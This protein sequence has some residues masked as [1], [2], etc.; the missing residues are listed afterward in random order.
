MTDWKQQQMIKASGWPLDPAGLAAGTDFNAAQE[1]G[2]VPL[3]W[4]CEHG[5]AGLLRH[6]LGHGA[7]PQTHP[8]GA[9]A[10]LTLVVRSG[11]YQAVMLLIDHL[12][13]SGEHPPGEALR[14]H[15]TD[16]F[17]VSHTNARNRLQQT[18][19][20]WDR[21]CKGAPDTRVG[22]GTQRGT[23]SATPPPGQD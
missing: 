15:L 19:R 12:K 21:L 20:D 14:K 23:K 9:Q 17:R 16:T 8:L 6:L 11:D 10:L 22:A 1:G 18:L 3:T 2:L 13:A 7:S 5:K 4:A